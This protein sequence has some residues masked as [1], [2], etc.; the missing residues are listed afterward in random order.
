ML[1]SL[2]FIQEGT[3]GAVKIGWTSND[4]ERRRDNLQIGNSTQLRLIAIVPDVVQDIEFEWHARFRAHQKR[5]EW[6][7]P[8]A[9]LMAAITEQMPPP[10]RVQP[11]REPESS[12]PAIDTEKFATN[13][14]PLIEWLREQKLR[15]THFAT[16]IGISHG[17]IS[18]VLRGKADLA[19]S[20]AV[21]VELATGGAV[22]ASVLLGLEAA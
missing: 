15:Q 3:D 11:E 5:S 9:A 10:G 6:F 4:P 21:Q 18:K 22:K 7:Y 12:L 17:H 2:Y 1:G 8:A 14:I 13:V 19:R 16:K 20:F